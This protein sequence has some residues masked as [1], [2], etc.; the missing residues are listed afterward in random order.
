M[1]AS[2]GERWVASDTTSGLVVAAARRAQPTQSARG[3]KERRER[4][5]T[6]GRQAGSRSYAGRG[7]LARCGRQLTGSLVS[8]SASLHARR[9]RRRPAPRSAV[10]ARSLAI[11]ASFAAARAPR[12]A[13]AQGPDPHRSVNE[14]VS[15]A[16]EIRGPG[17]VSYAMTGGG[18]SLVRKKYYYVLLIYKRVQYVR[19]VRETADEQLESTWREHAQLAFMARSVLTS[20]QSVVADK[21]ASDHV[22]AQEDRSTRATLP[23][24]SK[25]ASP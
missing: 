19:R 10:T 3:R 23:A 15:K 21:A 12:P 25:T 8:T 14:K 24:K 16:Q 22:H 17:N 18:R 6:A 13:R 4:L 11:I 7:I 20:H 2:K 1:A 9:V 5:G